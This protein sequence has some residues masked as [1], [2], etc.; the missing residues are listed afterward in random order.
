MS[1]P[2]FATKSKL[3][4]SYAD[5]ATHAHTNKISIYDKWITNNSY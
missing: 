2:S 3:T 4:Q 5:P 1:G